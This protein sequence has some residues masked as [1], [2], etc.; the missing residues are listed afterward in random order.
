[1][2]ELATAEAAD[3]T[4]RAE[5]AADRTWRHAE[6]TAARLTERHRELPT[7][8]DQRRRD[9]EA[10]H[11]DLIHRAPADID[12]MT[13]EAR[14]RRTNSTAAP[15]SSGRKHRP[16]STTVAAAACRGFRGHVIV[17][18]SYRPPRHVHT[19]GAPPS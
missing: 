13:R 14:Q 9:M 16:I 7:E 12:R 2:V 10:E 3:T 19:M 15:N 5:V 17:P 1:M 8:L 4:R 6:D 18:S 11:T